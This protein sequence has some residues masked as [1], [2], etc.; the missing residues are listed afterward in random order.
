METSL[1]S[2]TKLARWAAV[3]F[4]FV[5]WPASWW[6]D[7]YAPSKVFVSG[8]PVAT[9]N[10]LL[11]NEFIFRTGM[12]AHI[13]GVMVF[14][15]MCLLLY[16]VFSIVDKPLAALM[17]ATPVMEL[18]IVFISEMFNFTAIMT[19]TDT[20]FAT[21]I[22]AN[23]VEKQQVVYF[24]IRSYRYIMLAYEIFWGVWLLLLGIL[25]FRSSLVPRFIGV[26]AIVGGIGYSA[27]GFLFILLQYQ[28]YI[29]VRPYL[30]IVKIIGIA[31]PMLWFLIRGVQD[32]KQNQLKPQRIS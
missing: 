10:N 24:L 21:V 2:N 19:I 26:V 27:M 29:M 25:V 28:D 6:S 4:F 14:V 9:A 20:R 18:V 22:S 15:Y 31:A 16:R 13:M 1:P 11:S 23:T 32:V 5:I 7:S 12:V 3:L 8:D 30:K 17:M